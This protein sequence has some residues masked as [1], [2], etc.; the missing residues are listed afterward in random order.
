MYTCATFYAGA[1]LTTSWFLIERGKPRAKSS[2]STRAR[3]PAPANNQSLTPS[4][5]PAARLVNA[6]LLPRLRD[7]LYLFN[8]GLSS[9]WI[10]GLTVMLVFKAGG[11]RSSDGECL[12]AL[13]GGN[14]GTVIAIDASLNIYYTSLFVVP[15]MRGKFH[16]PRLKQLAIKSALAAVLCVSSSV[17]NL[18][19]FVGHHGS[20]LSWVCLST[21]TLDTVWCAAV[22]CVLTGKRD[23]AD[24]T[25][26]VTMADARDDSASRSKRRS[27]EIPWIASRQ[28]NLLASGFGAASGF[29]GASDDAPSVAVWGSFGR[30]ELGE[31]A[32]LAPNG[33]GV[34]RGSFAPDEMCLGAVNERKVV[35]AAWRVPSP[36][37]ESTDEEEDEGK[38]SGQPS[39]K[40]GFVVL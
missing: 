30:I 29:L 7:R 22:L 26:A 17:I 24:T 34:R 18:G 28:P 3:N 21:C 33:G 12:I 37:D 25:Q 14:A 5:L 27:A 40:V 1:K 4:P 20:E 32:S 10:V 2:L 31:G 38:A 23:D 39:P 8:I 9:I 15:L 13:R 36:K 16:S 35:D 19:L 6:P 11:I